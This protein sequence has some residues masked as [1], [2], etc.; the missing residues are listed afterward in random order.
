MVRTVVIDNEQPA[1]KALKNLITK[2]LDQVELVGEAGTVE[3]GVRLIN[4][5]RPDLVFLDIRLNFGTGF[6]I[7]NGLSVPQPRVI[8][9][10]AYSE[11]ALKAIKFSAL[12]YLLKPVDPEELALAVDKVASAKESLEERLTV[13]EE[14]LLRSGLEPEKIALSDASGF[15]VVKLSDIIRCEG[16]RNYTVFHLV[17]GQ[18][19]TT[20]KTLIEFERL[21][22]GTSFYRIYK[23]HLINLNHVVEYKKGRVA[24]VL[25]TDGQS[26]PV[27]RDKKQDFIQQL[28]LRLK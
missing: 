14:S 4:T 2:R 28:N 8:F 27:S 3:E 18:S 6:D 22:A 25:M 23:S 10:T 11:Y 12:D 21:L 19:I 15:K 13:L 1:R 17:G 26:L 5:T 24:S 16:E 7:L 20:T 9:I